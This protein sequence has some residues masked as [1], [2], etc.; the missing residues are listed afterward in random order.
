MV[1]AD[2][3]AVDEMGERLARFAHKRTEIVEWLL[4]SKCPDF[5]LALVGFGE[6][7]DA[8]ELLAHGVVPDHPLSDH[9]SAPN[10]RA[11]LEKVYEAVSDC[12]ARLVD[13]FPDATFVAITMH[14]MGTND[15][16]VPTMV[17]LPELAYR[18]STGQTLF[19]PREDWLTSSNPVLRA[20]ENWNATILSRYQHEES[21]VQRTLRRGASKLRQI[22]PE[23]HD[24]S[25]PFVHEREGVLWMPAM[26][27][28]RY[29]RKMPLFSVPAYFDGRI[30]INLEGRESQGLVARDDYRR[31]LDEFEEVLRECRDTRTG[32]PVVSEDAPTERERSECALRHRGRPPHHLGLQPVRFRAPAPG[33]DRPGTLAP[34]GRTQRNLRRAPPAAGRTSRRRPW[35]ALLLRRRC[36]HRGPAR[37]RYESARR[38][39]RPRPRR[40]LR[41]G[42]G[43]R[44]PMSD[45]AKPSIS[46]VVCTHNREV[47]LEDTLE[48]WC[49]LD[50][51][52]LEVECIV[53]DNASTD[54]T[55]AIAEA[56]GERAPCPFRTLHEEKLGLSHARN[57]GIR[58]S[59]GDLIAFVDDDIF[60]DGAWLQA[61]VRAAVRY[62]EHA[63]FGGK[64]IPRYE[65]EVPDW[66]TDEF[67]GYYGSTG[68][69]D[70]DADMIYPASPYGV[71][72]VFRREVFERVGDFDV[73]LGRIGQKLLSGE[74][75]DL[76]ERIH[77]AG[78]RTKYIADAIIH[79][80][81]PPDRIRA[82]WLM[83]RATGRA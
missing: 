22:F 77:E 17:L 80:R 38:N 78:L 11:A 1:Y 7:H 47:M 56:A 45:I 74:E 50:F 67:L 69:G 83:D 31:V 71:N 57:L 49:K 41:A 72:M 30:R 53:V 29:W 64:T 58:E 40:V 2:P 52:D 79:H 24:A 4:T 18:Y 39:E 6:P 12:V 42:H 13:R 3:A 15:T 68:T 54:R 36:H 65:A 43:G 9:P 34:H 10:A 35:H 32:T 26:Q 21:V 8:V 55:R 23:A 28:H 75:M 37:S 20:D 19:R 70:E 82:D 73:E 5:E 25:D 62:P 60:L 16:D 76:F 14:G 81:I 46:V 27:Y 44:A 33:H 51:T 63:C 59:T 48:S 61:M 66:M